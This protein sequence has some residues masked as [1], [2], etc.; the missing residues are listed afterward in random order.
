MHAIQG[1]YFSITYWIFLSDRI[2]YGSHTE[3]IG[4]DPITLSDVGS[5]PISIHD[6]LYP[7]IAHSFTYTSTNM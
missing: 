6:W 1:A 5:D 2:R 7:W 3:S 4:L